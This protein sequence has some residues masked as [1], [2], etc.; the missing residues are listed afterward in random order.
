MSN[1]FNTDFE[2]LSLNIDIVALNIKYHMIV[3]ILA[4]RV[5]TSYSRVL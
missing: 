5:L 4:N 1:P 3:I 2:H